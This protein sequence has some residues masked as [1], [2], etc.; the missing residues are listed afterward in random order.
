MAE[1]NKKEQRKQ[2]AWNILSSQAR[3]ITNLR[4]K[5]INAFLAGEINDWFWNLNAIREAINCDL[6]SGERTELDGV[7]KE[8][9]KDLPKQLESGFDKRD[10]KKNAVVTPLIRKYQRRIMDL[11][12]ALGYFPS[13]DDRSKLSF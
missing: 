4:T 2:I 10:N 3:L 5:S 7:E 9:V 6:E 13:K 1:D 8:I 11:L 12:K